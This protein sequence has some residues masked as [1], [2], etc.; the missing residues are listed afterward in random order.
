MDTIELLEKRIEALE[1][2]NESLRSNST[3]VRVTYQEQADYQE[4]QIRFRTVFETSRLGN[5]IIGSNLKILQLN[6]AMVAPLGYDEKEEI[7][8]NYILDYTPP[9]FHDDWYNL[10]TQLWDLCTPSFNLETCLK[11]RDGSIIWCSVTSILFQDHGNT[12]GY[13]I[14]EDISEQHKLRKHKE[15][16]ISIASHELKT[17]LTSLRAVL[18]LINRIIAKDTLISDKLM[19][20]TKNAETYAIMTIPGKLTTP[21]RGKLT[22]QFPGERVQREL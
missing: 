21:F 6:A 4:S 22:R 5:K 8:G 9:E 1:K 3:S 17:P 15:Y 10:Q 18:Q 2:E 19:Q 11:K 12:L 7:I 14:I 13:T 20:L 16:F